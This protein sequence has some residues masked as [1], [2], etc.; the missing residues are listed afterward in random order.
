MISPAPGRGE[1]PRPAPPPAA[2]RPAAPVRATPPAAPAPPAALPPTL[3]PPPAASVIITDPGSIWAS[4]RQAVARKPSLSWVE[5]LVLTGVGDQFVELA[6]LPGRREVLAFIKDF[7]KQQITDLLEGILGRRVEIRL[8]QDEAAAPTQ[9]SPEPVA[10]ADPRG[11]VR[12]AAS[13]ATPR[14]TMSQKD[15]EEALAQPLVREV[16]QA[17]DATLIDVHE[18]DDNA[19][20]D[21]DEA[22]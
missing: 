16:M 3:P 18:A 13:P 20:A 8:S 22:T 21:P 19:P 2:A 4:V 9:A 11:G 15:R 1:G 6:A 12:T 14:R 10:P 17:F 5:K 7:Q